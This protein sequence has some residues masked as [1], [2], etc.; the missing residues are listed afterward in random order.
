MPRPRREIDREQVKALAAIFCTVDEIAVIMK[1]GK[2]TL[3][4]NYKDE[5]ETGRANACASLRREQWRAAQKG[6]AALLI[7]L[8]KQ[9]LGQ[10]DQVVQEVQANVKSEET[11]YVAEWSGTKTNT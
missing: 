7:W 1:I 3:E 10:K 6:S 4:R 2:R 5:I 9:F 8:G 11:I